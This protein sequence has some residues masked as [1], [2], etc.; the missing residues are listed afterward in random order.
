MKKMND[1]LKPKA[2]I[3]G[4]NLRNDKNFSYSI[5]ELKNLVY[6]CN[7]DVV[8]VITQNLEN[9]TNLTILVLEK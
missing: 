1:E 3:V 6:A 5:E 9:I 4:V 2:L 8:G 7:M